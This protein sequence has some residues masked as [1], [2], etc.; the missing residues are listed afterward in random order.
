MFFHVRVL[1]KN[2]IDKE[3]VFTIKNECKEKGSMRTNTGKLK[4]SSR[5]GT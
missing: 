2:F 5:S 3:L 1:E 4:L